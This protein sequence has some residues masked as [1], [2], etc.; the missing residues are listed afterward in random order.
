MGTFRVTMDD[1]LL[2]WRFGLLQ[3]DGWK[4]NFLTLTISTRPFYDIRTRDSVER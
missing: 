3:V 1:L 2:E 4:R